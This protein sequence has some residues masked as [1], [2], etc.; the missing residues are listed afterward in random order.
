MVPR[1]AMVRK[2]A[3]A[4]GLLAAALA[5]CG[6]AGS[7]TGLTG[8]SDHLVP[9]SSPA[10][11]PEPSPS[12]APEPSPTPLPVTKATIKVLGVVC[13]G[14]AVPGSENDRAIPVGCKASVDLVVKGA[15]NKPTEPRRSP[16]WTFEGDREAVK[17][18]E[19]EYFVTLSVRAEGGLRIW[20]E[21][22]DVR[23]NVLDLVFFAR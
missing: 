19:E 22:D 4:A 1:E 6:G 20:V 14:A 15:D 10:P 5:A 2:R 23:S 21:V 17:I 7:P 13:E 16:E 3:L 8:T 12:P 18:A 11:S 9:A